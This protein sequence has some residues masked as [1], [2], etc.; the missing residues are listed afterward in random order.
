MNHETD[1]ADV[2]TVARQ[3]RQARVIHGITILLAEHPELS[4]VLPGASLI[5]ESVRWSA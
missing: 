5:D 3:L 2:E 1:S 4:E